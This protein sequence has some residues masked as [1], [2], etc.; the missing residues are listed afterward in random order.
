MPDAPK[1]GVVGMRA[2]RRDFTELSGYDSQLNAAIVQAGM[3]AATPV[4]NVTRSTLPEES[5]RGEGQLHGDVRVTATRT[6]A[7]VRMGR[8]SIPYAGWIEFGG[9]R[10]AP[11]DS[12]RPFVPTGQYMF[13]A[14]AR[15]AQ[16]SARLYSEALDK[17]L[18]E[19]DWTNTTTNPEA[20]HD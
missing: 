13:P 11:H 1:V 14:A 17:G 10:H 5:G 9:T 2:L 8:K 3:A 20:V 4:A 16:T 6:G 15:L 19:V 18:A 12:V 7:A